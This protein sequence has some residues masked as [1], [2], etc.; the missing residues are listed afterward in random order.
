MDFDYR[1]VDA[2]GKDLSGTLAASTANDA[3]LR[4]KGMGLTVVEL[5]EG[6]K[7]GGRVFFAGKRITD[8]DLYNLSKEL[9]VLLNAG[10]SIDKALVIIIESLTNAVLKETMQRVLEDIKGGKTLSQSFE[11]TGRLNPLVSI[12]VRVGESVGD[13]KS[14]FENVAEYMRFQMQFK[15]EIRNAMTYPLFLV[16]ASASIL[17]AIF[18]FIIPRFFSIFGQ[19]TASLPLISRVLYAVSGFVN[20]YHMLYLAAGAVLLF[21]FLKRMGRQKRLRKLY[22][23]LLYVPLFRQLLIHLELSRFS[24][25]MYSM[26]KSGVEFIH[27]LKLSSQ[28]IQNA[29]LRD[30]IERTIPQIKEGK[31]IAEVFSYIVFFPPMM[32]GMLR[33]GEASGNLKDIFFELYSIFDEKFRNSMKRVLTLMEPALIT[34]MGLVVGVIV[35]SLILTVMSVSNIK[36]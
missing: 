24:Y 34:V 2:A 20:S 8:A 7:S 30:E 33:V 3:L 18:K 25:S 23:Y 22:S 5:V 31:G 10:I 9:S 15:G 36:L 19:N 17:I 6:R 16:L 13:L 29:L 28:V 12:M 14:A 21:F 1:C 35:V 26:L 32:Q 11:D 4:L 27:A